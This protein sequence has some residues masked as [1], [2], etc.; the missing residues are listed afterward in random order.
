M[1]TMGTAQIEGLY[2]L[3]KGEPGL[4]KST[5]ALSYPTPQF[6][7]SWDR[8]MNSLMLPMK[9]W[10]IDPK[11]ISYEDYDDWTAPKKKLE[12]LQ[13]NCPFKTIV[14]DSITSMADMTLRQTTKMKY[15]MTRSSG[16]DAGKLIAGIAVNEID[17]R[18]FQIP[19]FFKVYFMTMSIKII[20]I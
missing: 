15:G 20:S 12:Q 3:F 17:R 5:Q 14:L 7:F 1:P 18:I 2:S 19:C 6:W 13:L 16:K 10:G 9:R 4:R 8:K 11:L